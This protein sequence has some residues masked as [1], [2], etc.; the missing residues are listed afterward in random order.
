MK[1]INSGSSFELYG[2]DLKTYDKLPAYTYTIK[3]SKMVGFYLERTS[4]IEVGEPK[5]YGIHKKKVEKVLSTFSI[6]NRNLGVILSGDKGIGK[7][8]FVRLLAEEGKKKGLPVIIVEKYIPNISAYISKIDQE[9][10]FIFDEFDKT[11]GNV[12]AEDGEV[13]PQD[14]MLTL[15]DGIFPGKKLFVITCNNL[16]NVSD[17]L[18]NRPGRFHYHFR[19]DYPN[20]EE[21]MEYMTDKLNPLYIKE[22]DEIIS[23]S[24]KVP[25]NY[26]CL[27]AIA[28]EINLG[29]TFKDAIKDLNIVNIETHYYNIILHFKEGDVWVSLW[30]NIDMFSSKRVHFCLHDEKD[31]YND[32]VSVSFSPNDVIFDFKLQKNIIPIKKCEITYDTDPDMKEE[33]EDVKKLHPLYVE[34]EHYERGDN[35]HY[36]N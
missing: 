6:V 3:F 28:F 4:D 18:V 20:S 31:E 1:V 13:S 8:L 35:I 10:I 23:F 12:K 32:C 7:S 27:R 24:H 25:L 36:Y 9:A 22:I 17:Y 34:L 2:D 21:I 15:F 5:V 29:E 30:N 16:N 14:S 26:D 11:F 19:F 33:V